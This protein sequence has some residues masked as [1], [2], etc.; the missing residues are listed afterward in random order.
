LVSSCKDHEA[1]MSKG[2]HRQAS[3]SYVASS[4]TSATRWLVTLALAL[5][6]FLIAGPAW[7]GDEADQ[8]AFTQSIVQVMQEKGVAGKIEVRGPLQVGIVPTQG[9]QR[10][11]YLD[12]LYRGLSGT[13]AEQREQIEAFLAPLLA[14]T[15]AELSSSLLAKILP[16][17]RDQAFL[18]QMKQIAQ[19]GDPVLAHKLIDGLWVL[20]VL[21]LPDQMRFLTLADAVE[22]GSSDAGVRARAKQNLHL[23]LNDVSVIAEGAFYVVRLDDNYE[24]SLL[25]DDDFWSQVAIQVPGVLVVAAPNRNVLLFTNAKDESAVSSLRETAEKLSSEYSYPI[26]SQLLKRVDGRWSRLD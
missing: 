9:E 1:G 26:T 14:P 18:D 15:P 23:R 4:G 3:P 24:S 13:Q 19:P 8:L 16:V 2:K 10:I 5:G 22:L 11:V 12:N 25:V 20:Y 17:V 7:A 21:D 6:L